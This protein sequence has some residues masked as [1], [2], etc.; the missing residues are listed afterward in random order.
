MKSHGHVA[1]LGSE[2]RI[3]GS[4]GTPAAQG[5]PSILQYLNSVPICLGVLL[6]DQSVASSIPH[7]VG[8]LRDLSEPGK[9]LFL[10]YITLRFS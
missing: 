1:D 5:I 2:L 6:E 4:T 3:N 8:E 10:Q 7:T 9:E